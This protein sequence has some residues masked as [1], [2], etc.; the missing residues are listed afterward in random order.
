M[1]T[2]NE[3]I[4][5]YLRVNQKSPGR[6][7]LPRV[8]ACQASIHLTAI[9]MWRVNW[10][11]EGQITRMEIRRRLGPVVMNHLRTR[12]DEHEDWGE[13]PPFW[14]VRSWENYR[15]TKFRSFSLVSL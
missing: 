13:P 9:R 8:S 2:V 14:F 10:L 5:I 12:E 1:L 15:T 4:R 11:H 6:R 3:P 7:E